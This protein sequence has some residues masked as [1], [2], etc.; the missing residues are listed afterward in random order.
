MAFRFNLDFDIRQTSPI[1]VRQV[2]LD[3]TATVTDYQSASNFVGNDTTNPANGLDASTVFVGMVVY[4]T[5]AANGGSGLY[6]LT[7]TPHTNET[8]W[9][10]LSEARSQDSNVIVYTGTAIEMLFPL[11]ILSSTTEHQIL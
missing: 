9:H 2:V 1:D 3:R 11:A 8:N 4:Q 10:H 6:V 5:G 7:A